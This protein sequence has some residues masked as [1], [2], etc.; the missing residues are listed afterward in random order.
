M[1]EPLRFHDDAHLE[2]Q[3]HFGLSAFRP[4]QARGH[5][6]GPRRAQR[7]GGDA[8]R[9]GQEPLLPAAGAAAEG[10]HP[11]RLA[12]HRP[13]EGPGG[14]ARRPGH[15]GHRSS[16]PPSPSW[17]GPSASAGSGPGAYR[18][19]YVAPERFRS[20]SFVEAL[21]EVGVAL[22]AIDEAHCI[23]Q[24]GHDFRPDY[25]LLGQVRKRLRPP[26]T[27]ALTATATPEVRE[28]IVRSLLMKDPKVFVAGFDRPNLFLEVVPGRRATRS[29]A[30]PAPG[31]C[32]E[33]G[34]GIVYCATRKQA[35]AM[36]AALRTRGQDPVVYHAGMDEADRRRGA[37]ALHERPGG[38][39]GGHQRL[40]HGHRQAR[41]PLRHPRQHPPGGRGLLPG[42]GP[43][44]PRREARPRAAPL[45]PRRR[46]H[47][48]AA[49]REQPPLARRWWPTCGASF[50]HARSS[51]GGRRRWP[52]RWAAASSRSPLPSASSSG[53]GWWSCRRRDRVRTPSGCWTTRR[54][55]CTAARPRRC[56]RCSA[57]TRGQAGTLSI[58]LSALGG[59]LGLADK[60]L[61]RAL[62][63]L[64]RARAVQVRRPFAGRGIRALQ[65][66]PFHALDLSL[67]R[68]RRQEKR[69][70]LLL[71]RM[72]DYAYAKSC[73][74]AFLL[75]YF[76]E[77]TE[78]L[79][80]AG[81]RRL[82]RRS[83]PPCRSTP[84]PA[85][86][87]SGDGVYKARD[88]VADGPLDDPR[89][90]GAAPL[91]ARPVARPGH[92]ALHPLHRPHPERA[93]HRAATH[94]GGLPGGEGH[95]AE[96]LGAL[97]TSSRG[98]LPRRPGAG[99]GKDGRAEHPHDAPPSAAFPKRR[100]RRP[101][102]PQAA[103]LTPSTDPPADR[104][105]ASEGGRARAP[106]HPVPHQQGEPSK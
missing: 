66:V 16:T 92:P 87:P 96:Q 59:R 9:R 46:L 2:L 97:R 68:V 105:D 77:D 43:R 26:R 50:R 56:S 39:G 72:T 23:S 98:D 40:R 52:P 45:Q 10:R 4:G 83:A 104:R 67:E 69:A 79:D 53:R 49:H 33:G 94:P 35:D 17:S 51:P 63:A 11:G 22:L 65:R 3:R 82:L 86:R 81:L 1:T 78:P 8:H 93:G 13:D 47:P 71:R 88:R 85:R 48:G 61:R 100:V 41:H 31:S 5:R 20:P 36:Q 14:A 90:R 62:S 70:L 75:S 32:A 55:R 6:L 58:Q 44:R 73:R 25:A 38:G 27:V 102:L 24:W 29:G 28:D 30:P 80:C 54:P 60:E 37:G 91:P 42:G 95:R 76:G 101:M 19:V 57:P 99:A 34:G 84:P 7:G 89:R 21:A 12:A 106:R 64:E 15:P 18:L 103:W 74:R